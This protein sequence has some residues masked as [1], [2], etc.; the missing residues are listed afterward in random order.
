ECRQPRGRLARRAQHSRFAGGAAVDH[1]LHLD[2]R[3]FAHSSE[4][5]ADLVEDG[6]LRHIDVPLRDLVERHAFH[7][8]RQ[9]LS[10]FHDHLRFIPIACVVTRCGAGRYCGGDTP[11]LLITFP[12]FSIC[13][14]KNAANSSGPLSM[15]AVA[16][17]LA[18][19]SW[20]SGRR[21]AF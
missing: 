1:L 14:L 13:D 3:I 7:E 5:D 19:C 9:C 4:R 8:L 2:P 17:W 10:E 18:S 11:R 21:R 6:E 15:T 12:Y 16:P 20:T